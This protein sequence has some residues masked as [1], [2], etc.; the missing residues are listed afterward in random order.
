MKKLVLPVVVLCAAVGSLGAADATDMPLPA[1]APAYKAPP[2]PVYSWTGCYLNGGGGYGLW[3]QDHFE[4][5]GPPI[6]S[7]FVQLEAN[8]TSGGSGGFGTVGGGCDYQFASRWVVGVFGDYNFMSLTGNVVN[9]DFIGTAFQFHEKEK[10]AW[11]VGGRVGYA[12]TPTVLAYVNG[13]WTEARF[14]SAQ[15]Y[16]TAISPVPF[17][18]YFSAQTYNG[19]FIGGGTEIALDML[20]IPGLFLRSEYRWSEYGAKNVAF[21]NEPPYLPPA[22]PGL[23]GYYE[24]SKITVQ[25]V[26]ASLLWRFNWWG[27]PVSVRD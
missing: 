16:D 9:P 17:P 5:T 14:G 11:A 26:S 20:P 15:E 19:W 22:L 23:S 3:K 2:P 25:T 12:V 1:K 21:I 6:T 27:G 7:T 4:E 10:N 24:H 13:G 8:S 18:Q